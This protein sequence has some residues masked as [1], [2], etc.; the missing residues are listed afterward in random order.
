MQH[1]AEALK[2]TPYAIERTAKDKQQGR[3]WNGRWEVCIRVT[4][5]DVKIEYAQVP[6]V[7]TSL[8]GGRR[9]VRFLFKIMYATEVE[10]V[11]IDRQQALA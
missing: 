9:N 6:F 1:A 11:G 7:N 4:Q 10:D 3:P 8:F 2:D 5:P